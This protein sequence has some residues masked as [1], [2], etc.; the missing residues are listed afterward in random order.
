MFELAHHPQLPDGAVV[1]SEHEV[2]E[3][4]P[5]PDGAYVI[6]AAVGDAWQLP[7]TQ[8]QLEQ[9]PW[10]GP[11]EVPWEHIPLLA[12]QPQLPLGAVVQE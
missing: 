3:E 6:G 1:Q 2:Q 9:V 5:L 8:S 11:V 4:H 10:L 12:H 7:D